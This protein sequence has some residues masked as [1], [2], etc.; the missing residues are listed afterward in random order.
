MKQKILTWCKSSCWKELVNILA[1]SA[2]SDGNAY[3]RY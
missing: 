1:Q 3:R 2:I